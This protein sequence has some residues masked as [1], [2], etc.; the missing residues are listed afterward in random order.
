MKTGNS[1]KI[2][3]Q[4]LMSNLQTFLL[5]EFT[6]LGFSILSLDDEDARSKDIRTA[7]PF[8]RLHRLAPNGLEMIE[9]QLDK[10]GNAAFRLNIGVSPFGGV[11][12]NGSHVAQ[13]DMWVHYL[14]RYFELYRYPQWRRW[15]SVMS[16][17]WA[18]AT[19]DDYRVL[20]QNT[21][22]VIPEIEK[23]LKEG[24]PGRHMR[25]VLG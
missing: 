9:I 1:A 24:V 14:G 13:K 7:F 17:P 12:C 22:T 18:P 11:E 8:G 25:L 4:W 6:R 20:V 23:A 16:L 5:P 19:E 15:F 2:R 10:H 3:K 21:V